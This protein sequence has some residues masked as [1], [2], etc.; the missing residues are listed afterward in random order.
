[1][2]DQVAFIHRPE[3]YAPDDHALRGL[4]ELI[5]AKHRQGQTGTVHLTWSGTT[6]TFRNRLTPAP[7]G[8]EPF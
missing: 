6:T 1:D 8:P 5:V 4:A 7:A 3:I 2:A